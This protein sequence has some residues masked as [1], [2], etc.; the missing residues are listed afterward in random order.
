M[1]ATKFLEE[2]D[3]H[4]QIGDLVDC[5]SNFEIEQDQMMR[6]GV[7]LT[8]QLWLV[9]L[10]MGGIDTS[11]DSKGKSF[12]SLCQD[13]C[14]GGS[15]GERCGMGEWGYRMESRLILQMSK[16]RLRACS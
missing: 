7:D 3:N 13:R 15:L 4:P 9:K 14:E 1:K 11:Y 2:L 6:K 10:L 5:T 8:P 12:S 16:T